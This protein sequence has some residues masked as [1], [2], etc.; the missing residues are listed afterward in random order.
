MGGIWVNGKTG[1][2]PAG[3]KKAVVRGQGLVPG[4]PAQLSTR[5]LKTF[6]NVKEG[7]KLICAYYLCI[8]P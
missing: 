3:Q 4:G 2:I 7:I 5:R 8:S 6:V 1:K